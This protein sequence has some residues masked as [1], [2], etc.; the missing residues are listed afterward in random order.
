M[1]IEEINDASTTVPGGVTALAICRVHRVKSGAVDSMPAAKGFAANLPLV[2][3]ANL[4]GRQLGIRAPPEYLFISQ[5][6]LLQQKD[7][8]LF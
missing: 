7:K 3:G 2:S 8:A 6:G 4:N 5:D 1:S